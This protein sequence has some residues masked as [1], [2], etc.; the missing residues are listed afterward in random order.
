[1]FY[2]SLFIFLVR[3]RNKLIYFHLSH[4]ETYKQLAPI[5]QAHGR[6]FGGIATK[7]KGQKAKESLV[8]TLLD[9][10]NLTI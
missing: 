6:Y 1:M 10:I 7:N 5:L 8:K 3:R 9:S 4:R 2:G